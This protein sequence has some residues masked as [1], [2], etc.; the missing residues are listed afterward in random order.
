MSINYKLL[1]SGD[2]AF[3]TVYVPGVG[4]LLASRES[5]T[6]FDELVTAAQ[7]GNDDIEVLFDVGRAI[8]KKF[9]NVVNGR[10]AIRD[11]QVFFDDDEMDNSIT[12]A[13]LRF[14]AEALDFTPLVKFMENVMANPQVES[15][16]QFY[17]WLEHYNFP[18]D[19][20]GCIVA[21]KGVR[22]NTDGTY[23]SIRRGT[24][25]T[26][27]VEH[28]GYIPNAVGDVV[29]MPRSGVDFD[30]NA[31]CSAGLHAGT[32]EYAKEF[33]HGAVMHVAIN[34][35]DV[36]SVPH[37][38]S[39]QKVRVCR[40]EVIGFAEES[41]VGSHYASAP[42]DDD[43]EYDVNG[44]V[45]G[46]ESYNGSGDPDNYGDYDEDGAEWNDEPISLYKSFGGKPV[47]DTRKNHL[48]QNRDSR[49]HFVK[50]V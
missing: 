29:T 32:Y 21:Y 11:G 37:D 5:H 22:T 2:D 6:N 12:E 31:A 10:V 20:N 25:F 45:W 34:P 40:Y 15:R 47:V 48:S 7:W 28:T 19:D 44:E 23:T 49:G 26:N 9:T 13:I 30:P 41:Y 42:V 1:E 46:G 16:D 24:A 3:L 18:I 17:R 4:P 38:S 39:S 27:D 14:H 50:K 33:S 43:Y 8:E 36:V 35:R